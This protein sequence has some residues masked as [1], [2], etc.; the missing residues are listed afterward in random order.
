METLEQIKTR[1]LTSN[2]SRIAVINFEEVEI[3]DAEFNDAVEKR[4]QMEY[5]Q[6]LKTKE[7]ADAKAAAE[8]K[9]AALGLTADDLKAL[10][11]GG[12]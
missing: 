5:E 9:L 8:A 1:I 12:N 10:G 3:T 4:A 7:I 2:P 6:Q 11:L